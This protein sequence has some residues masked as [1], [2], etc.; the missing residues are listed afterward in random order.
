MIRKK[1]IF[2]GIALSLVV[3]GGTIVG[4]LNN[5]YKYY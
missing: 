5:K 2:G 3:I 4:V 1:Y